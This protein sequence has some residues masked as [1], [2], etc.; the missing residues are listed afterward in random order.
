MQKLLYTI[1]NPF[2]K[3]IKLDCQYFYKPKLI[4]IWHNTDT[5]RYI[6]KILPLF[7]LRRKLFTRCNKCG[8]SFKWNE[9]PITYGEIP[10]QGIG[11]FKSEIGVYHGDC[12][13]DG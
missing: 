12:L 6:L 13:D 10:N 3:R 2:A 11:W 1:D 7:K 9:T 4:E 5:N 8:K